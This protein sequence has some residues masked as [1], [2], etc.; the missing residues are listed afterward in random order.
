M[1]PLITLSAFTHSVILHYISRLYIVSVNEHV[2][3]IFDNFLGIDNRKASFLD[4]VI[5][6]TT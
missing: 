2:I 4:A 3:H 6:L 5:D 1:A